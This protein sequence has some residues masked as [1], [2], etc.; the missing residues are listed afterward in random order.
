MLKRTDGDRYKQV[1]NRKRRRREE[2][3]QNKWMVAAH[4]EKI[5]RL[6]DNN[7]VKNIFY[8]WEKVV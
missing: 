4:E 1:E 6:L 7:A 2:T 5:K 3:G 8:P